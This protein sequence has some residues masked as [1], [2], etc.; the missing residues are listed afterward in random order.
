[1]GWTNSVPIFHD[2]V[3]YILQN[4]ILHWTIPFIDDVL[5]KGPQSDYQQEDGS[6]KNIPENSGI[7]CFVW[8][9]FGNLNW[10]AQRMKN[11]GGAFSGTKLTL[12]AQ[13][14][15]VLGHRSTPQ[16]RLPDEL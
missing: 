16:G 3:T 6:F 8:E 10:V 4:K 13:E 12:C 15:I 7:H 14:T 2:D 11:C 5:V 9:H 1:M